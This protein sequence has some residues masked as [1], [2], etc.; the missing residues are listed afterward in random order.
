[1]PGGI[2]A[3]AEDVILRIQY[4][5]DIGEAYIGG[6]LINDNFHNGEPWEIGL[7]RFVDRLAKDDLVL[8]IVPRQARGDALKYEAT[9]MAGRLTEGAAGIGTLLSVEADVEYRIAVWP[10]RTV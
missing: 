10:R 9:G 8:K 4:D 2:P 6:I 5:G 3:G 7:K 1:M